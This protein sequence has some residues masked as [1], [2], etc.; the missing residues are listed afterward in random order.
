MKTDIKKWFK[1]SLI[2]G[3]VYTEEAQELFIEFINGGKYTFSEVTPT[4]YADFCAAESQGS[5][6]NANFNRKKPFTVIEKAV[7][8]QKNTNEDGDKESI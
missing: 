6:F 4:E 2:Q 7:V 5:F 8:P 3:S 1:S